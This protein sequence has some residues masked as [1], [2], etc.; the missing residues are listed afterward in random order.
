[1]LDTSLTMD[2]LVERLNSKNG[3]A[4]TKLCHGFWEARVKLN[5]LTESTGLSVDD[6]F[7]SVISNWPIELYHDLLNI[8]EIEY[9]R[10]NLLSLCSAFGWKGGLEIEGTPVEGISNVNGLIKTSHHD[11]AKIYDG[12]FWKNAISDGDFLTFIK[13]I[14]HRQVVIIGPEYVSKFSDFAMLSKSHFVKVDS[15]RAAWDRQRIVDEVSSVVQKC[16]PGTICLFQAG[17]APASWMVSHLINLHPDSFFFVLG[18]GLNICNVDYLENKNW[19]LV[20]REAICNCIESINP[21]WNVRY[22]H[23][24]S[25]STFYHL[26][27]SIRWKMFKKGIIPP[28][29]E[30]LDE[31]SEPCKI[32]FIENK[33]IDFTLVEAFLDSSKQQNHWANFG[34]ATRVL[35]NSIAKKLE[36]STDKK[37]LMTKSGTE[38]IQLAVN[39]AESK[40]NRRLRW[41]VSAFGFIAT[42]IMALADAI[43]I[44]CDKEGQFSLEEMKS[45]PLDSWDG[46]VVTNIFG[47]AT[48]LKAIEEFCLLHNKQLILDNATGLLLQSRKVLPNCPEVISFHQTKP[49]GIGEG[50]CL[51]VDQEGYDAAKKLINFG[52]GATKASRRFSSNG[53]LSDFNSALIL[54]RLATI[55]QWE[56]LYRMQSRRLVK[57]AKQVGLVPIS[58]L[59]SNTIMAYVPFLSPSPVSNSMLENEDVVLRK[60]YLPLNNESKNASSIYDRIICIPCHQNVAKISDEKLITLFSKFV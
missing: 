7:T 35:E 32:D 18:Q 38:A 9:Q 43:I 51:I 56:H 31:I 8:L 20:D 49:W 2:F 11:H 22:N 3:I 52:V 53:K 30:R 13:S 24:S 29:F 48:N 60:Y 1:M 36:L 55:P 15:K 17:G 23:F 33:I 16:G 27:N 47:L 12:L 34:P 5:R 57:L 59:P 41:V 40:V 21:D 54:Y 25:D 19:F 14:Q 39:L 58:S 45:L 50:G 4:M 10:E 42:N 28:E 37:V 44:D 6:V 26:K 46:V